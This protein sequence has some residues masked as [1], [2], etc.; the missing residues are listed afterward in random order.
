MKVKNRE[1]RRGGAAAPAAMEAKPPATAAGRPPWAYAAA[2]FAAIFVAFWAYEPS[3]HGAFLF[4]DTVLP[5]ALPSFTA[6]FMAWIRG[7]RPVLMATYWVNSYFWGANSYSFHVFNVIFHLVTTGF[8][9]L[10]VRRLLEWAR[11]TNPPRDL[12]AAFAAAIFL[13]HPIQTESVAYLAGRSEAVSVMILYA[14]FTVFLYRR[15]TAIGWGTALLVLLLFGAALLSKEHTI[16]LPALLLLTDYWW[17]PGFSLRG[18]WSNWKLYG[19]MALGAAGG[20]AF[21][22]R[23]IMFSRSAGF[24][25]EGLTWYQYFFTQCR[26]LFIYPAEFLFP[27]RLNADWDFPISQTIFDHGAIVGLIVLAALAVAAW[28]YRKR[29]PLACFGFFAY[30]LLMAPT[31]SILPIKD[32]VAE[33]RIY[34]SM[35]GLLLIVVDILRN[36]KVEPKKLTAILA[37]IV[38]A[39][40]CVTRAR[41]AIWADPVALWQDAAAKSPHKRRALFQLASAYSD[42]GRY[43]EAVEQYHQTALQF[44][45]DYNFLVDWALA[46]DGAGEFQQAVARLRQAAVMERTAHVY[47]QLAKVYAERNL[48]ADALDALATAESIDGNYA[49]IFMYRGDIQ[50]ANNQSEEAIKDY[51]QALALDPTLEPVIRPKLT[52]IVPRRVTEK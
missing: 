39:A 23:L 36:V 14:A 30:L 42:A 25:V 26:A 34:L 31:S 35:L 19:M 28:I 41:S 9:F 38:L 4:D 48:W 43:R 24:H 1:K 13:L 32:P 47:T 22:W 51:R 29:Y 21:F 12:L 18:A 27:V 33:R 45:P 46:C 10:I 3:L 7:V 20:V 49:P 52:S 44:R 50:A 15:K 11:T 8:I 17:N 6:P 2:C 37:A 5:F 16:A 40:A